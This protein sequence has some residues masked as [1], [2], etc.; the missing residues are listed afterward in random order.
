MKKFATTSLTVL[1][2]VL[3]TTATGQAHSLEDLVSSAQL[4]A[5][6]ADKSA[7]AKVQVQ[8]SDAAGQMIEGTIECEYAS[9]NRGEDG[10]DLHEDDG[11]HSE[12]DGDHS[13]D[14]GLSD[15][16][17]HSEGDSHSDD[18][19][20]SEGDSHSDDDDYNDDD[21]DDYDDEDD[22]D[23]DEDDDHDDD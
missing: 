1:A 19:S 11:D 5:F 17:S 16:D 9:F 10:N 13:E 8:F 14:D 15:D 7:N 4:D 21:D 6:C 18:D 3:A 23:D 12:D 2:L 20:H 22:D